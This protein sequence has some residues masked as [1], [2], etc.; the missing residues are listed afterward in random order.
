MPFG[1]GMRKCPGTFLADAEMKTF[2]S[3]LARELPRIELVENDF[4]LNI[5][6]DQQ[7]QWNPVSAM[8]TPKDGVRIRVLSK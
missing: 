1:V 2:L 4:D 6:L 3:L 5:P 7:I 8:I